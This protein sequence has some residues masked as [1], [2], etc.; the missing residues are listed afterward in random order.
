MASFIQTLTVRDALINDVTTF[1]RICHTF[2]P[3]W[4]KFGTQDAYKN[5]LSDLEFREKEAERKPRFA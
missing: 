4:T 3:T 5:L 2:R 1:A